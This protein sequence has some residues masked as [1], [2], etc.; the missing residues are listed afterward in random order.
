MTFIPLIEASDPAVFGGKAVQLGAALRAGLP[1]P[2][3]FAVS[4]EIAERMA[5][6]DCFSR[7][8]FV[9]HVGGMSGPLAVRSSAIGEDSADASFAGQHA[10][11]LNVSGPEAALA[12]LEEVWHSGRTEAA[13]SYRQRMGMAMQAHVAV[14]VQSLVAADVAGVLFTCNPVTGGDEIV[15]EAGWGLGESIVQGMVVPDRFRMARSGQV[16][17][18]T[19]GTKA[20]AV[21][22]AGNGG[23]YQEPLP[24]HLSRRLCLGYPDLRRLCD[25]AGRCDEV[26]GRE[27]HDVEWALRNGHVFL[28]QRRPVTVTSRRP[29]A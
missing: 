14:V 28:L 26:F 16:I 3:G 15:V 23:T 19:A 1:V 11:K 5:R 12:A 18:R 29:L 24:Q 4:A 6:G 17:E 9:R 20:I 2:D 22:M 8:H 7:D 13:L 25:L 27:P 10:T 21:R